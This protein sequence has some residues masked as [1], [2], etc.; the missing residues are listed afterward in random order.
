MVKKTSPVVDIAYILFSSTDEHLRRLH[1]NNLINLYYETLS[2]NLAKI[3]CD[4]NECFPRSVFEKHLEVFMPFGLIMGCITAPLFM[5]E[6][7]DIPDMDVILKKE[8]F[9]EEDMVLKNSKSQ[10]KYEDRIR[11]IVKDMCDFNIV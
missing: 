4:I 7:E 11:G 1:Y 5:S 3:D 10:K 8:T 2:E 9:T 6:E